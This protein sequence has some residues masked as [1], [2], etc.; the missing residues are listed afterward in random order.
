[1]SIKY[2]KKYLNELEAKYI[3]NQR[4]YWKMFF[5]F[6]EIEEKVINKMMV[7]HNIH[8]PTRYDARKYNL[9]LASVNNMSL[10]EL[11]Y[12]YKTKLK[13]C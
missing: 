7:I 5:K 13:R 12:I 10:E 8:T 6:Q 3:K 11:V 9:L 1:M 4:I 2:S